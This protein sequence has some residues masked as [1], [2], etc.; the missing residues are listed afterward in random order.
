MTEKASKQ[1]NAT[2]IV[3]NQWP[4]IITMLIKPQ[5]SKHNGSLD[6]FAFLEKKQNN[7]KQNKG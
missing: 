4:T 3:D 1:L 2:N 6:K 5:Q 7:C